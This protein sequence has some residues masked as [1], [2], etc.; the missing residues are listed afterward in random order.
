M[1]TKLVRDRIRL[2]EGFI[3]CSSDSFRPVRD[4]REHEALLIKKILEEL[5]ELVEAHECGVNRDVIEEGGD[6][7]DAVISFVMIRTGIT[8]PQ[9]ES[10]I[11]AKQAL[12]GGFTGGLVWEHP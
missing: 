5:S 9:M 8:W 7:V 10:Q 12:K 6:L 4:R 2:V 11:V 3:S 1:A